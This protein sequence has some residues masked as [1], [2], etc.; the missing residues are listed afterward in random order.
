MHVFIKLLFSFRKFARYRRV[1]RSL[2]FTGNRCF[3]EEKGK[4]MSEDRRLVLSKSNKN[5]RQQSNYIYYVNAHL[6]GSQVT[7]KQ[8]I[9]FYRG[10]IDFRHHFN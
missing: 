2:D 1:T 10:D 3:L 4:E 6:T 7:C 5:L 9:T 8:K